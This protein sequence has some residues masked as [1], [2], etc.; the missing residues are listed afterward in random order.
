MADGNA[1]SA[2][3]A[4]VEVADS[5]TDGSSGA[6]EAAGADADV[7]FSAIHENLVNIHGTAKGKSATLPSGSSLRTSAAAA[8]RAEVDTAGGGEAVENSDG[9]T[10]AVT[11][12]PDSRTLPAGTR[13]RQSAGDVGVWTESSADLHRSASLGGSTKFKSRGGSVAG[14]RG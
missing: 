13:L 8:K 11:Q 9:F 2:F 14:E 7:F 5:S 1:S 4:G 6:G 10:S 12:N 3:V